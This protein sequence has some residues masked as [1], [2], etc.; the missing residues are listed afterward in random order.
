[1]TVTPQQEI[2]KEL[3]TLAEAAAT[4]DDLMSVEGISKD[5]AEEIYRALH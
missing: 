2:A 3:T 1:M 4:V 5:L